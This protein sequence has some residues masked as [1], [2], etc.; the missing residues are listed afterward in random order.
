MDII[1][2]T[3]SAS[4][5]ILIVMVL[6]RLFPSAMAGRTAKLLWLTAAVRLL[7]P[8][9]NYRYVT[10]SVSYYSDSIAYANEVCRPMAIP[11]TR[12]GLTSIPI[13]A[14]IPEFMRYLWLFGA[15]F[16][17][18]LFLFRHIKTRRIFSCALP[19]EY[20]LTPL[21]TE[22]KIRRKVTL[23][24]SDMTDTPFTYGVIFPRIILPKFALKAD[25]AQFRNILCHELGHIKSCDIIYK[26]VLTACAAL[27]W[28]NPLV[29]A[30]LVLAERDAELACDRSAVLHGKCTPDEYAMTLINMEE[31]RSA[32]CGPSFTGGCLKERVV[33]IMTG[34]QR[35]ISVSAVF[36]AALTLAAAVCVNFY[37]Q[38]IGEVEVTEAV[39][40]DIA[41]VSDH[42]NTA[43]KYVIDNVIIESA[44]DSAAF[45][46]NPG[47]AYTFSVYAEET[48]S[49]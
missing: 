3:V 49:E 45:E 10:V 42:Y 17:G 34:R 4:A 11:Y 7:I 14:D 44:A 43:E 36:S 48:A 41:V 25:K 5:V 6:R 47:E 40:G 18:A 2:M 37:C 22:Y 8:F 21:L 35:K 23:C 9:V 27:H 20:D 19:C 26:A 32:L 38:P 39:S 16:T 29:W 15:V 1:G 30:M 12:F 28:F 33:N 13:T 46:Y 31:R 24:V